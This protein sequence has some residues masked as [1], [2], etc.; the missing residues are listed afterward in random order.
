MSILH[1]INRLVN[2]QTHM[3]KK[4]PTNRRGTFLPW[5]IDSHRQAAPGVEIDT[6]NIF[7]LALFGFD[8]K[9]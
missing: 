6:L 3:Q 1:M 4:T 7:I 2:M 9:P 5:M 8:Y